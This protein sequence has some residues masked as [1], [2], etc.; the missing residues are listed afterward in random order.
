[1][2]IE[3]Q[4][5]YGAHAVVP[6]ILKRSLTMPDTGAAKVWVPDVSFNVPFGTKRAGGEGAPRELGPR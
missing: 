4:R 3:N 5:R 6:E 1:M 2:D